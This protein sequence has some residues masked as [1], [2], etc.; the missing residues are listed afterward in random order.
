VLTAGAKARD[1]PAAAIGDLRATAAS[2]AAS[3]EVAG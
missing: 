2:A 3:L 1:G